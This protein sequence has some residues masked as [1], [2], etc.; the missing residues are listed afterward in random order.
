M[1]LFNRR[2]SYPL[3]VVGA[4]LNPQNTQLWVEP[5]CLLNAMEASGL[6][7][8]LDGDRPGW[9]FGAP[10]VQLSGSVYLTLLRSPGGNVWEAKWI[11]EGGDAVRYSFH[12]HDPAAPGV[13]ADARQLASICDRRGGCL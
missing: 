1:G 6:P 13:D 2:P 5:W 12:P 3:Y 9:T 11:V 8:S 4:L 10:D 7:V